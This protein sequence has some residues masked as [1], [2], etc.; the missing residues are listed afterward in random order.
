M[1][2]PV[3]AGQATVHEAGQAN[4]L[5]KAGKKLEAL[6]LYEDLA[7]TYPNE[8]IYQE[9]L[10][11]C[12][13]AEAEQTNDPAQK[14]ALLTRMRDAARRAVQLGEK[15][16]FVQDMANFDVDAPDTFAQGS[17]AETLMQEAEKAFAAGDYSTA[18]AKYVA[19]AAA[20]PQLYVAALYAG[21]AA[22]AQHD[23]PTAAQWFAKAIAIDPN[24]ETA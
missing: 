6:P 21:D 9:R 7:K 1:A 23:L 8:M 20:D 22:Y 17:S 19:A 3:W 15:A 10:A 13:D 14:K 24:R 12:L 2:C 4:E 11:S 5:Y 18:E 16:N